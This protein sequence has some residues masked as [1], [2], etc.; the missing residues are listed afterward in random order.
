MDVDTTPAV[1]NSNALLELD[2]EEYE[3]GI[4]CLHVHVYVYMYVH[5]YEHVHVYEQAIVDNY[6]AKYTHH[7]SDLDTYMYMYMYNGHCVHV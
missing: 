5:V 2:R 3:Q 7:N 4:V 6:C 1:I